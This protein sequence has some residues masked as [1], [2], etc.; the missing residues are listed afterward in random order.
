MIYRDDAVGV[1]RNLEFAKAWLD[2][3]RVQVKQ[4][5]TGQWLD[6]TGLNTI[7]FSHPTNH[8]R[9]RP[10]HKFERHVVTWTDEKGQ[11]Q[12]RIFKGDK[13][14]AEEWASRNRNYSAYRDTKV[15]TVTVTLDV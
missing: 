3:K 6:V 11:V 14:Y 13:R 4:I 1:I 12:E 7:D 5:P 8:Y 10:E 9:I 2:G 15:H